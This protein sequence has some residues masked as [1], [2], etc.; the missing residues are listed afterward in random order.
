MRCLLLADGDIALREAS[1]LH[2]LVIGLLDSGVHVTHSAPE[3]VIDQ[4]EP[5]LGVE[6][7]P[8]RGRGLPWT[9]S[10]RAGQLLERFEVATEVSA[11][12]PGLV[13]AFGAECLPIALDVARAGEL[14]V[15]V[16]VNSMHMVPRVARVVGERFEGVL[17]AGSPS[18]SR[19]L[20]ASGVAAS[21]VRECSWG[22]PPLAHSPHRPRGITSVAI[23]GKG[24]SREAWSRCLQGLAQVAA[25]RQDLAIF[26]DSD[27]AQKA[28]IGSLVGSLGLS[29]LLSRVPD[30]ESRRDLV[31]RADLLLWPERLGEVRSIVLDAMAN[32]TPVV[33]VNDPD[34]PIVSDP[35]IAELVGG[36]AS[37]WAEAIDALAEDDDR[38]SALGAS[39]AAAVRERHSAAS[40]VGAVVD[41]YEWATASFTSRETS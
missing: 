40:H 34:V 12:D 22:V 13:H 31:I 24:A 36:D 17:L 30:F 39:A 28:Q 25:D 16:D 35:L 23:G 26:V 20:L 9:R 33:A 4:I 3:S 38:R 1:L 10:I 37:D 15:V 29:P 6:I 27:A 14:A 7:L 32:Y 5:S 2:R 19:A 8:Y 18:I 41:A 21:S 11:G